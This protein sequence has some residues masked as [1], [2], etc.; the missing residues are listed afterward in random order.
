[1]QHSAG[2]LSLVAAD[3]L[4]FAIGYYLIRMDHAMPAIMMPHRGSMPD[5]SS[6]TD[7]YL[8]LGAIFIAIRY[9]FGDY[10][11]RQLFWDGTRSTSNTLLLVAIPDILLVSLIGGSQLY[12]RLALSW[13]FL[14]PAIPVFR[15]AMR[16]LMST[17]GLWQI[18]TALI[19]TGRKARNA[20]AGLRDTLSLGFDVRYLLVENDLPEV[21]GELQQLQRVRLGDAEAIARALHDLDC[22]QVIVSAEDAQEHLISATIQRLLGTNINVAII[23]SL[24]G[25]P[26]FGLSM[27]YFFG[28]DM[29]LLQ[30]R[31]NLARVPSR[32]AK[33][34][35]DVVI[36]ILLLIVLSPLLLF[37]IVAIKL[38]DGGPIFYA[39]RRVGRNG[40]MFNCI[41]FRSMAVDADRRL[42]RWREENPELYE[43][44]LRTF[45]LRDDPRVTTLGKWLRRTSLDELPQLIN[46]LKGDM[47]LVG[48]RPIVE[49]EL[50]EY[51]GPAAELYKRVRPG[52]TG[53]WQIS[54]RS[55]TTYTDRVAYDEWYILNWSLWYDIV[56]LIHT[57][58]IV[59]TGKGAF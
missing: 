56:I 4:A 26:L 24:H 41:K 29:L 17:V 43:K 14:F 13:L 7:V 32:F 49:H 8:I 5:F 44:F 22:W 12:L 53:M 37:I 33:R 3:A 54:G 40:R 42:A 31:N 46:V 51:Y 34:V 45:K 36:P 39:H 18:P 57:A 20:Y 35:V 21:P 47:S 55:N 28:R 2:M 27:N 1:M 25:L 23:P 30:L 16:W 9:V 50:L 11:R 19:G 6:A 59:S 52:I 15:Q 10:T 48:P 38:E 58:W